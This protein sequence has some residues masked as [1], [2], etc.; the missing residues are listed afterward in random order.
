MRRARLAGTK[1][2]VVGVAM[3][4]KRFLWKN[5]GCECR[6]SGA[7]AGAA[8]VAGAGKADSGGSSMVYMGWGTSTGAGA[9]STSGGNGVACTGVEVVT[10]EVLAAAAA[11]KS[12]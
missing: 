9:A 10:A 11:P 8:G 1:V 2:G 7:G 12:S 6:A 5:Q 3:P 4:R